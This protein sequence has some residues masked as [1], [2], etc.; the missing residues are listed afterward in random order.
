MATKTKARKSAKGPA[1]TTRTEDRNYR[2]AK[3]YKS[4]RTVA[5]EELKAAGAEIVDPAAVDGL[6][7]R[8]QNPGPCRGFKYDLEHYLAEAG[9]P[10]KTLDDII[11]GGNF[12]P[13]IRRRLESAQTTEAAGDDSPGW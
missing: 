6:P 12:H 13:T 1:A 11:K 4:A 3:I 10:I 8:P 9:A 5:L 2:A 7:Q